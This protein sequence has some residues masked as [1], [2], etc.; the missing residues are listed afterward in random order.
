MRKARRSSTGIAAIAAKEIITVRTCIP[1]SRLA[2]PLIVCERLPPLDFSRYNEPWLLCIMRAYGVFFFFSFFFFSIFLF[3][4]TLDSQGLARKKKTLESFTIC[5]MYSYEVRTYVR[6]IR[7]RAKN[8][9]W[10]IY[11]TDSY[12]V[13][14]PLFEISLHPTLSYPTHYTT[15]LISS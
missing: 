7:L 1:G 14:P 6:R 13:I 2:N 5:T 11:I 8:G 15:L 3:S 9:L 10:S 12:H 4:H